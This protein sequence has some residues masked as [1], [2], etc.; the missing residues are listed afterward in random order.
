LGLNILLVLIQGTNILRKDRIRQKKVRNETNKPG[1]WRTNSAYAL[2]E[3]I[4]KGINSNETLKSE[5]KSYP[6]YS[7]KT[8]YK[9]NPIQFTVIYI[10]LSSHFKKKS[11]I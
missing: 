1:R 11:L 10:F 9:I 7:N 3:Y 2:E 4:N 8:R 5:L 6:E